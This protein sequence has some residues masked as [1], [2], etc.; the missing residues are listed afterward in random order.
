[1]SKSAFRNRGLSVVVDTTQ[2]AEFDFASHRIN[3]GQQEAIATNLKQVPNSPLDRCIGDIRIREILDGWDVA[4]LLAFDKNDVV[5]LVIG[6]EAAGEL[7][8]R[9]NQLIRA[10]QKSLP[11]GIQALLD[12]RRTT[13]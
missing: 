5:V 4:F 12:G 9:L 13:K 11:A 8:S 2:T 7:E 1:L 3:I 6:L 10:G